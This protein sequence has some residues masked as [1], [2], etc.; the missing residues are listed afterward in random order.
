M[1]ANYLDAHVGTGLTKKDCNKLIA[2]LRNFLPTDIP[3]KLTRDKM[4]PGHHGEC[5]LVVPKKD[6]DKAYYRIRINKLLSWDAQWVTIIHE[7]AHAL[8][9]RGEAQESTRLSDHDAEWGIALARCFH[10][11][12]E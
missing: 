10:E 2:H 6:P 12:G 8:Q 1:K 5:Y 7:Y 3:V 4:D 9:W 11:V